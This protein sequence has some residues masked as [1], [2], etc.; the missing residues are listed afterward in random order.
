MIK[1]Y[2]EDLESRL[3]DGVEKE[4][5]KQW[6]DFIEGRFKGDIF[7]PYRDK[8]VS[9]LIDWPKISVNDTLENYDLMALQQ[10]KMCSDMLASGSGQ[11]LS[12]RSNYGTGIMPSLF[13]AELFVMQEEHN[14]LPTTRPIEGGVEAIKRILDKGIPD[15][16][17]GLGARVFEMGHRFVNI[18]SKYPLIDKHL[19][20][21]HPD[22]QGPMDICELLVGS[23]LF[24]IIMDEPELVHELLK[25]VCDTYS[26][27]MK[28]WLKIAPYEGG[29]SV[30]W[31]LL[32]KGC[33]MLRDD[34]A[35]N[36]S[37]ALFEE[38]IRPYDERLLKEFGGG[39]IHF[40]GRGDHY[41]KS[42]SEINGV[43]AFNM[44]QPEYNNM[45][46]IYKNTVDKGI[47]LLG[48]SP[49]YA[50]QALKDGIDLHSSV[51][52]NS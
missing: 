21:Y 11:I 30:H 38:F 33:L 29:Y 8:K 5:Y 42:A 26:K 51:N 34:S 31:S 35:M 14:T 10:L 16:Y 17:N 23:E 36:F 27:F 46:I 37:P 32:H 1:K 3:E 25:L 2:L 22:M 24:Y 43:Y 6:V 7:K 19:H 12:I 41:I 45:N 40:C 52:C 47:K 20:L 4:I 9:P 44:S 15:I 50:K 49:E 28:E 39:A 13:G 48:F 18:K